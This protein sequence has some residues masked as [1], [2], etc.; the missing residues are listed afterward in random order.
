MDDQISTSTVIFDRKEKLMALS[1]N[2]VRDNA[3]KTQ[4][5]GCYATS[6]VLKGPKHGIFESEFFTLIRPVRV[7]DLGTGEK[8]MTFRKLEPLFEGFRREFLIKRTISMR[9]KTKKI[10]R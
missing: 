4:E 1:V 10:S 5:V 3:G 7:D 9:L 2:P 8:K 6:L